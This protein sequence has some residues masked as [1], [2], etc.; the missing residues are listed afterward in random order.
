M[1]M[2]IIAAEIAIIIMDKR[3]AQSCIHVYMWSQIHSNRQ[4]DRQTDRQPWDKLT[5]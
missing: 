2:C 3:L 1:Y 5:S 4:T